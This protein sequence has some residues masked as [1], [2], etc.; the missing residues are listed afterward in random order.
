MVNNP[1]KLHVS[2][3]VLFISAIFNRVR[4]LILILML[5]LI[6]IKN[7]LMRCKDGNAK[8]LVFKNSIQRRIWK[9]IRGC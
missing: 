3:N 1:F 6:Y 7:V 4:P 5:I 8:I 9:T 2:P